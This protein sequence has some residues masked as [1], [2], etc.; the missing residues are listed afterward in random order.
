MQKSNNNQNYKGN[1]LVNNNNNNNM[2]EMNNNNNNNNNDIH[3]FG[4]LA[5]A[6]LALSA[7]SNQGVWKG[8]SGPTQ[9]QSYDGL[10]E[11]AGPKMGFQKQQATGIRTQT[12]QVPFHDLSQ[13]KAP[14]NFQ[15]KPKIVVLPEEK[16]DFN[17]PDFSA[18]A[19]EVPFFI[20]SKCGNG[21]NGG[22]LQA[23]PAMYNDLTSIVVD[24]TPDLVLNKFETILSTFSNDI[25]YKVDRANYV[26]TGQVYMRHF[27]V[28]F[29]ISIWDEQS[30][31]RTRFEFRRSKGDTVA[32]TEFWNEIED[33]LYKQ[34]TNAKG[35][36]NNDE[37][38]GYDDMDMGFDDDDDNMDNMGDLSSLGDLGSLG[39]LPPLD[40]DFNLDGMEM[41]DN[42]NNNMNQQ[43]LSQQDLN[44]FVQDIIECDPSV[45]Y[46]FAM[47]LNAFKVQAQFIQ[48]IFS[49]NQ[50]IECI[51][52]NALKSQDTAL[53][54]G[55]LVCIENLCDSKSGADSLIGY[56]VLDRVI[57][58]L[59]HDC[60]LIRK[61]S[62]RVLSKLSSAQSWK[63]NQNGLKQLAEIKLEEC[64]NKWKDAK[65]ATTDFIQPQMFQNINAKLIATK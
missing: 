36:K 64:Q 18:F 33:E 27:A 35:A 4:S 7:T 25:D 49:H 46:S 43:G 21:L 65:F 51:I 17:K 37:D 8:S 9:I 38:D 55:A 5:T 6:P 28:F 52:N 62:V 50:F 45:V 56:N 12:A 30:E 16:T 2:N 23:T 57:P 63:F 3:D 40:Y 19:L 61:Y 22:G 29:K 32:F 47:I 60:D 10:S 34:F 26:I 58:L 14:N 11:I 13:I 1:G 59:Q 31:N 54:R 15:V 53:L 24:E 44:N 42:N 20:P 48:M 41:N 39:G